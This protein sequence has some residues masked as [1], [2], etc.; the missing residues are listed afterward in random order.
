MP[1]R[2]YT[3]NRISAARPGRRIC[4][5][6]CLAPALLDGGGLCA[7]GIAHAQPQQLVRQLFAAGRSALAISGEP[8]LPLLAADGS[9]PGG[10]E[11]LDQFPG[12][13]PILRGL[14]VAPPPGEP[15][16]A[17]GQPGVVL[18]LAPGGGVVRGQGQLGAE[19]LEDQTR[20]EPDVRLLACVD[21]GGLA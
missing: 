9:V 19:D 7:V 14:V 6:R 20:L 3:T 17:H 10:A 2:P 11:Q 12:G 8:A 13:S 18:D 16:E 21:P 5:C 15:G 1:A 4:G